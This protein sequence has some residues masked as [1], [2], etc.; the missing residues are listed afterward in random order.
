M[1][2]LFAITAFCVGLGILGFFAQKALAQT[3]SDSTVGAVIQKFQDSLKTKNK[4]QFLS[5]FLDPG[6]ATWQPV[7]SDTVL[8]QKR[9]KNPNAIKAKS[10]PHNTPISFIDAVCSRAVTTEETFSN[11]RTNADP[12]SAAISFDYNFKLD[13]QVTNTGTEHWALV[14]TDQGW[15]ITAVTWS[16]EWLRL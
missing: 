6:R 14:R 13:G 3:T 4:E 10:D 9:Q 5:L 8:A 11:I 2:R 12:D 16:I 1:K 7:N 15:R